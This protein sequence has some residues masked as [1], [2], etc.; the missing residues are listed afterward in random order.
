[1][2]GPTWPKVE[3]IAFI[4]HLSWQQWSQLLPASESGCW[5]SNPLCTPHSCS[6][7]SWHLLTSFQNSPGGDLQSC[8]CDSVHLGWTFKSTSLHQFYTLHHSGDYFRCHS[9]LHG[10]CLNFQIC[11]RFLYDG[12]SGRWRPGRIYMANAGLEEW[13][14]NM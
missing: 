11:I 9:P 7:A 12:K 8:H 3:S 6:S 1:M 10:L 4:S 2:I 13:I 14:H 5:L